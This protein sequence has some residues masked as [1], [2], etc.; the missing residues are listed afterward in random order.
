MFGLWRSRWHYADPSRPI[1]DFVADTYGE[2]W[3]VRD[4]LPAAGRAHPV[5]A[6]L[7]DGGKWSYLGW[8][9]AADTPAQLEK[10]EDPHIYDAVRYIGKIWSGGLPPE[11]HLHP[12][13]SVYLTRR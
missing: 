1:P 11:P 13:E 9:K 10:R 8:W 7:G 12:V 2:L 6:V 3:D 5:V 4:R